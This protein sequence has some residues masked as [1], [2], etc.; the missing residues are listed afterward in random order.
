M[1]STAFLSLNLRCFCKV[2]KKS[3]P[4]KTN[5]KPQ[6]PTHKKKKTTK[7]PNTPKNPPNRR[8]ESITE[9]FKVY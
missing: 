2:K 3:T 7:N 6:T 1:V 9:S 4:W 8:T 5:R